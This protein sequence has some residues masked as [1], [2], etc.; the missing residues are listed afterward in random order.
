MVQGKIFHPVY[1]GSCWKANGKGHGCIILIQGG[2]NNCEQWFNLSQYKRVFG[3]KEE[4]GFSCTLKIIFCLFQHPTLNGIDHH[5]YTHIHTSFML[6]MFTVLLPGVSVP[7]WKASS[8]EV[9]WYSGKSPLLEVKKAGF[10]SQ[11]CHLLMH[12]LGLK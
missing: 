9:M 12:H 10:W 4:S 5:D 3:R 1:S 8:E 2:V 7:L 11:F 6:F